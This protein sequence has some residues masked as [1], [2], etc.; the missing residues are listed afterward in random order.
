[1][2]N[3]LTTISAVLVSAVVTH[4]A[5]C[6]RSTDERPAEKRM[7]TREARTAEEVFLEGF[8]VY[9]SGATEQAIPLYSEAIRLKPGFADAYYAAY[10]KIGDFD[11]AIADCTEA[12]RLNREY[13]NSYYQRGI[14][15]ENLVTKPKQKRIFHRRD[16]VGT[17]RDVATN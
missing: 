4:F 10:R 16:G 2:S 12:I 9:K 3:V 8:A 1:M 14:A 6:G 15:C 5:G 17:N 13:A 11:Q 7:T